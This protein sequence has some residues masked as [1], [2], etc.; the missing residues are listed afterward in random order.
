MQNTAQN[1]WMGVDPAKHGSEHTVTMMSFESMEI[2]LN[3]ARMD[4]RKNQAII[5][6]NYLENMATKILNKELNGVEASEL[7][8]QVAEKI[9]NQSQH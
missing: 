2:M 1:I 5:V 9:L 4:E 6:S 8:F 3:D 7:F